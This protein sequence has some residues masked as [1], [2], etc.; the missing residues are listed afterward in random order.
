MN[1]TGGT[2]PTPPQQALKLHYKNV[3]LRK[4]HLADMV[5]FDAIIIELKAVAALSPDHFA[6]IMNYLRASRLSVGYLIN[7]GS[8]VKLEWRRIALE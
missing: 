7:F 5:A 2:Y 4:T 6:Q 8:P 3:L 1:S